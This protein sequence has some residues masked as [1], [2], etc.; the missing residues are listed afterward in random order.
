[1]S[2][3]GVT[4]RSLH[5]PLAAFLGHRIQQQR[6]HRREPHI[7]I[8]VAAIGA[9]QGFVEGLLLFGSRV[10]FRLYVERQQG[11]WASTF[12]TDFARTLPN[13]I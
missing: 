5:L 7:R 4:P 8:G 9:L 11:A 13:G 1:M 2:L 3:C 10:F 12:A 6:H